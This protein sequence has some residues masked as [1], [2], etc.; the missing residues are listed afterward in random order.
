[1]RFRHMIGVATLSTLFIVSAPAQAQGYWVPPNFSGPP[2]SGYEPGMGVPLPNATTAEQN[3][4]LIWNLR[5]GLNVAALQCAFEPTLRTMQNYNAILNDHNSELASSFNTLTAYFKRVNKSPA[6]GQKA[7][8]SYGTKTYSGFSTVRAQVG[9]CYAASR[10]GR[11]GL[12]TPKGR[13]ITLAQEHLRELRNSLTPQGE[14]QFRIRMPERFAARPNFA[15]DSC[16][17]KNKYLAKCG[18]QS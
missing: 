15:Q 17:K 4:A 11:I 2:V 3:A 7:L 1:M 18:F 16:W 8:D 12:F 10:I 14:Q 13:F 9:F 6:L 5:A